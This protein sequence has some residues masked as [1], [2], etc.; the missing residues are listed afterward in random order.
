MIS[1]ALLTAPKVREAAS[2][3]SPDPDRPAPFTLLMA[4]WHL[5][6]KADSRAWSG[7][8]TRLLKGR[9]ELR[10]QYE[11]FRVE[12]DAVMR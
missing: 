4:L 2:K 10:E 11:R 6:L 3:L 9:S 7:E 5:G 12:A 1:A 8:I